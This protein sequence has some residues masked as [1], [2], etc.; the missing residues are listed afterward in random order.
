M[1]LRVMI[2]WGIGMLVATVLT[3]LATV[4]IIDFLDPPDARDPLTKQ[5]GQ[6]TRK[7]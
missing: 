4:Y 2:I 5:G 6:D 3:I 1:G 7:K